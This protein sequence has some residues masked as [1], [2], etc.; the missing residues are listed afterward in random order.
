MSQAEEK[1]TCPEFNLAPDDAARLNPLIGSSP[2]ETMTNCAEVADFIGIA[3]PSI[4]HGGGTVDGNAVNLIMSALAS[5][6]KY[7]AERVQYKRKDDA[8]AKVMQ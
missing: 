5:A 7:E 6:L 8:A 4:D 3:A 2:G 1:D